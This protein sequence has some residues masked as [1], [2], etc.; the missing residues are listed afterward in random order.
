M[1]QKYE[2]KGDR[3]PTREPGGRGQGP[4]RAQP[5]PSRL[6]QA[7]DLS[8]SLEKH[9]TFPRV[10]VPQLPSASQVTAAPAHTLTVSALQSEQVPTCRRQN[11]SVRNVYN[12][13]VSSPLLSS[14]P[15]R[16]LPHL[17]ENAPPA[18]TRTNMPPSLSSTPRRQD[19]GRAFPAAKDGEQSCAHQLETNQ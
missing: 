12:T 3:L 17:G 5:G 9:G 19:R 4:V 18:P 1:S 14:C 11:I 15:M 6:G 8:P 16:A 10:P 7:P 2:R 13:H